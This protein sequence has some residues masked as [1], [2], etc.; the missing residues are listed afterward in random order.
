MRSLHGCRPCGLNNWQCVLRT[1][2]SMVNIEVTGSTA[3]SG[4]STA[5]HR[6]VHDAAQDGELG[7]L[8]QRAGG[9][10]RHSL[11]SS[12]AISSKGSGKL[13]WSDSPRRGY[14][15]SSRTLMGASALLLMT[16]YLSW[17]LSRAPGTSE[18]HGLGDLGF[19]RQ[20][21]SSQ[22][23]PFQGCWYRPQALP[24]LIEQARL[25]AP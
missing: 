16:S 17:L 7:V 24:S 25:L 18:T 5:A 8:P 22:A 20:A 23:A 11:A 2:S 15:P 3:H 4:R 13:H 21:Q 10:G 9:S 12:F 6:T 14:L 1:L 19:Y